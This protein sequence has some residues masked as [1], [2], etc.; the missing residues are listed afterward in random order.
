MRA[1]AAVFLN[2]MTE[3]T[4]PSIIASVVCAV[5]CCDKSLEK[6]DL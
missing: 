6:R 1:V 5:I 2:L 4:Q 3:L